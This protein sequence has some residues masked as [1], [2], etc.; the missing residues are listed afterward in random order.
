MM[1][2]CSTVSYNH[3]KRQYTFG[4]SRDVI[5]LLT[6]KQMSRLFPTSTVVPVKITFWP[7][8]IIVAGPRDGL[9]APTQ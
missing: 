5:R 9:N 7:E 3:V 2:A 6:F 8:T 4:L 1:Q